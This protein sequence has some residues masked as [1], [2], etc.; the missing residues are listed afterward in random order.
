MYD[1]QWSLLEG[2]NR[3]ELRGR[4][5]S[6]LSAALPQESDTLVALVGDHKNPRSTISQLRA[7]IDRLNQA[8]ADHTRVPSNLHKYTGKR[9]EDVREWL[10]QIENACRIN[11]IPIEDTSSRLPRI[12]GSAMEMPASGWLLSLLEFEHAYWLSTMDLMSAYY[13][14][15]M[16]QEDIKFTAFQAPNGLWG[17][18]VLPMGVCNAPATMHRLT[19]KLFRDL[20]QTKLT[21][22]PFRDLK[23]TKSF[24][25]DIYIFTKSPKIEDHLEALRETLDIL[26]DNKRYVKLSKCVFCAD[27]IPCLGDFVG[28][29]RVC[30]DPDK[31]QTIKD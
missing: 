18:L 31:V 15:R 8:M 11:N 10:F 28:R 14:V 9:G 4:R 7:E 30:M 20:K 1:G 6:S 24:Y 17:Y 25:D 21:S 16:R 13:Q 2:S 29:K 12:A 5:L 3:S 19:S 26:R 23:H 27:E 22:K